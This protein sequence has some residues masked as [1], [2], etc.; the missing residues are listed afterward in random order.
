MARDLSKHILMTMLIQPH[1]HCAAYESGCQKASAQ[2]Q[3]DEKRLSSSLLYRIRIMLSYLKGDLPFWF[4]SLRLFPD[5]YRLM[6]C[7]IIYL[8][9]PIPSLTFT[10][11]TRSGMKFKA[12][13]GDVSSIFECWLFKE[14]LPKDTQTLKAGATVVDIGA[15]I[16]LFSLYAAAE[17]PKNRIFS[18]EPAP[19]SF[20]LLSENIRANNLEKK[21]KAYNAA[22]TSTK[23]ERPFYVPVYETLGTLYVKKGVRMNVKGLTLDDVIAEAGNIDFL[24]MDTE[25]AEYEILLNANCNIL[26]KIKAISLEYHDDIPDHHHSEILKALNDKGYN[27]EILHKH[28]NETTGI[29]FAYR[30]DIKG[31]VNS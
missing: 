30:R 31:R 22:I 10:L 5:W 3:D 15:S 9:H 25:G 4:S 8:F 20:Q 12:R 13:I 24:K 14:Y 19:R 2:K 17:H 28:K 23:G 26:R 1:H 29:I 18:Y 7:R 16:G 11:H 21:V 6:I 27:V